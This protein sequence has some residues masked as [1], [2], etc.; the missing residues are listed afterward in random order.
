MLKQLGLFIICISLFG[1]A[2]NSEKNIID[3]QSVDS[4]TELSVP[5]FADSNNEGQESSYFAMIDKTIIN[6]IKIGSPNSIQMAIANLR[7]GAKTS[8]QEKILLHICNAIMDYAWPSA[9]KADVVITDLPVNMYTLLIDSVE[10]GLYNS[11][12]K[13]KDFFTL[14][15]PSLILLSDKKDNHNYYDKSEKALKESLDTYDSVLTAYLLGTL[16]KNKH[17]YSKALEYFDD[18]LSLEPNTIDILY[19]YIE[20]LLLDNKKQEAYDLARKLSED[21]PN[22]ANAMELYAKTA[23]EI[24]SYEE[25]L[26][27]AEKSLQINNK[28]N[29]LVLLQAEIL[30]ALKK[31]FESSTLLEKYYKQGSETAE[32]LLLEATLE[33]TWRKDSESAVAITEKALNLFGDNMKLRLYAAELAV[34]TGKKIQNNTAAEILTPILEKDSTNKDALGILLEDYFLREEWELAYSISNEIAKNDLSENAIILRHVQIC[35]KLGFLIE[36][37]NMLI[38]LYDNAANDELIQQTYLQLL[39]AEKNFNETEALIN[40]MIP[41]ANASVKSM[42][43]FERSKIQTDTKLRLA[44]LRS[45][46][47]SNPRNESTL[48]ELYSYYFNREDYSK[49]QYYIKQVMVLKPN[50]T[51]IQEK[52]QE[53]LQILK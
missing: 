23:Y 32:S 47:T 39:I 34:A 46:L 12:L 24:G 8:E 45:S 15:I 6:N 41:T 26:S 43:Y 5:S 31:F 18:A 27:A 20:V 38:P 13:T 33:Y 16:Y 42:L 4:G 52:Y 51:D 48:Y 21:F 19:A 36:A 30:F 3:K 10:A 44:D 2:T 9:D 49:A 37:R 28:S 25:A 53:L 7:N 40:E 1:C 22:T 14:T 35:L 17:N 11:S 29:S 50:A